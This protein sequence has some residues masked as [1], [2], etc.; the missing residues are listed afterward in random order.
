MTHGQHEL[1]TKL[2]CVCHHHQLQTVIS[3]IISLPEKVAFGGMNAVAS[4]ASSSLKAKI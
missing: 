2:M 4:S 1:C 3:Y